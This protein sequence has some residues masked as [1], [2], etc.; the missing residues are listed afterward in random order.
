[1]NQPTHHDSI[2]EKIE[3]LSVKYEFID[4]YRTT[5]ILLID[6]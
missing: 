6:E 1:M 4:G 3:N 2:V 5:R